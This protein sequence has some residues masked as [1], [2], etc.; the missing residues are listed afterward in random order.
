MTEKTIVMA[1]GDSDDDTQQDKLGRLQPLLVLVKEL[2]S[3]TGED[4]AL[5]AEDL[6]LA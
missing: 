6:G 1:D 5:R 4:K 2:D 3:H